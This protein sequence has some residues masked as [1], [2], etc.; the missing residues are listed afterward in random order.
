MD[1]HPALVP[2]TGAGCVIHPDRCFDADPSVRRAARELYDS[3]HALPIVSPHGHVDA[4]ILAANEAFE[5]PAAL[6]VT[7]D[8]Y[9][10]RMLYARG[11]PLEALGVP[12]RDGTP[13]E[14]DPR[15]IW[16]LFA[17]HYSVFRA[18]PSGMW[19]DHEL[20]DL[21]GF[22]ERLVEQNADRAYDMIAEQLA[23][24]EYRPRALF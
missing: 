18:T 21:F 4:R 2:T 22:G 23:S 15:A 19:L 1:T 13:V 9:M 6:L 12:R 17:R 20:D 11:V 7:P 10:L 5:N 16:R 14:A 8:H 3:T 24:P